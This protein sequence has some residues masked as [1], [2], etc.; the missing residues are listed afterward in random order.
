MHRSIVVGAVLAGLC[1]APAAGLAPREAAVAA[2]AAPTAPGAASDEPAVFSAGGLDSDR[3]ASI[4]QGKVHVV[5]ATATWCPPCKQMKATTWVDERVVAWLEANAVVTPLDVDRFRPDASRL[6]VRSMPTIMLF[7]G[8]TEIARTVGYQ[9]PAAFRAWLESS[10]GLGVPTGDA[11]DAAPVSRATV[12]DKL[13]QAQDAVNAG[14]FDEAAEAYAWLWD[15]ARQDRSADELRRGALAEQIAGLIA[16]HEAAREPFVERRDAIGGALPPADADEGTLLDWLALNTLLGDERLI[17]GWVAAAIGDRP[18]L[19]FMR[20][21]QHTLRP[22]LT[23]GGLWRD[24]A[25]VVHNPFAA[26]RLEIMRLKTAQRTSGETGLDAPTLAALADLYAIALVSGR[27]GVAERVASLVLRTQ[28][29]PEIRR[30]LVAR[31]IDADATKPVL[32]ELIA[33]DGSDEAEA[34]R[35]RVDR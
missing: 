2:L 15:H 11:G 32:L 1:A 8:S 33:D 10:T 13:A 22:V 17:G 3:R 18:S 23:R 4:D 5:Y 35:A 19:A 29:T 9:S 12:Q 20:K 24:A 30:A 28:D 31:A 27:A 34:L 21:H 26:A 14:R 16:Q 25:T 6:R 7:K